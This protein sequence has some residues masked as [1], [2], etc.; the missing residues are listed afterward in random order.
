MRR[1]LSDTSHPEAC[2]ISAAACVGLC[3]WFSKSAPKE[4]P[5]PSQTWLPSPSR[6]PVA[7]DAHTTLTALSA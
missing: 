1:G 4:A 3:R 7:S 5:P 2:G 6:K